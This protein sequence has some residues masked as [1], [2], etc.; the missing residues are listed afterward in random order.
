MKAGP[1]TRVN[2]ALAMDTLGV[3]GVLATMADICRDNLDKAETADDK[4]KWRRLVDILSAA[5]AETKF[6]PPPTP[7]KLGRG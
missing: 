5:R 2:I 7:L 4:I 1:V 3:A 6:K